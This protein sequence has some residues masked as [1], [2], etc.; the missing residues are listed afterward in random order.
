MVGDALEKPGSLGRV[1]RVYGFWGRHPALYAAQDLVT[2]IGRAGKIRRRAVEE[3]Q[4]KKGG[5]ALEVACGTGRN[6]PYLLAA[7]GKEGRLVGFDYSQEMLDA[8][9]ELCRRKGW[10]NVTLVQGDAAALRISG[11]DF[12]GI[13]S[14]LGISAV[15][16]WEAALRRSCELL[17]PGGRL[18][19][20]DARLFR[21]AFFFLNPLIRALYSRFAAWDPS[22]NIP[23]K[24]REI[25]GNAEVENYNF[26]TFFIATSVKHKVGPPEEVQP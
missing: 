4:L 1:R 2:F 11:K 10:G 26:G 6:F 13:L 17:R 14:V 24:M 21:G 20:C 15:P 7:I 3:L 9:R 18:V 25:F 16:G 23:D 8:A 22:K 12:D 5:K 19:V